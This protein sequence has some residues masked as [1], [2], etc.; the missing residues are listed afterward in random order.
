MDKIE[1]TPQGRAVC[2]IYFKPYNDVEMRQQEFKL[3]TGADY[4]TMPKDY[5]Y[6]LGYTDS[7]ITQNV[8]PKPGITTTASG[9]EINAHIVQLPLI[10]IYGYEAINWP[11]AIMLDPENDFRALLG[12]DLLGGFNFTFENDT[13]SLILSRTKSFIQ[14]HPF[15]PGQEIHE[16]HTAY[17][18]ES[19]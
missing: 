4:C 11:F 18:E 9:E 2:E 6:D 8:T 5:L 12:L 10:N 1:L 13:N 19:P 7:W 16:I 17:K 14:R 15:L 3:D